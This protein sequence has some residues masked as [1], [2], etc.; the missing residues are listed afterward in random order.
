M[1][2]M[3]NILGWLGVAE[4]HSIIVDSQEHVQETCRTVS[5]LAEAVKAFINND[6]SGKT[7]AIANVKES[8]RNADKIVEKIVEQL[9]EGLLQPLHREELMRFVRALDKIADSTNR[10][11]GLLGFIEERLPDNVL[12]NIAIGTDLIVASV[13]TFRNAIQAAGRNDIREALRYCQEIER[14]EH[15]ADD[16]KRTLIDTV[17]HANMSPA[18]L[19]VCYNLAEAL[20][21]ITDRIEIAADMVKLLVVKS[22]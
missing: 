2:E 9:S 18:C 19:I 4:E 15:E 7:T 14:L 3:R 21:V 12:K 10:T 16:Q 17:L 5:F 13:G 8:E 1:K 20:E 22:Q 6:L 11:A